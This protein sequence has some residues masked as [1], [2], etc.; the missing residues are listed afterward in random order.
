MGFAELMKDAVNVKDVELTTDLAAHGTFEI[1]ENAR[2]AGPR[3]GKG[4]AE[5]DHGGESGAV[6][7]VAVGAPGR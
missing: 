2:A 7:D 6:D 1:T 4:R 5:G 3:L